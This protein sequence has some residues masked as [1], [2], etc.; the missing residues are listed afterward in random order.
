MT[1]TREHSLLAAILLL[2]LAARIVY[3]VVQERRLDRLV[4]SDQGTYH[5]LACNLLEKGY[6]GIEGLCSYRSV[7]PPLYPFFL[8]GVYSLSGVSWPAARV[9][10]AALATLA[11]LALFLLAREIAG[12]G[13]ALFASLLFSVDFYLIHLS[14]IFL[15]ENL[16]LP[17]S[18]LL[19]FFLI[20]SF[21]KARWR[22][23]AL[24]G[25][26]AG[27]SALCRP[28]VILFLMLLGVVPRALKA[29]RKGIAGWLL[30]LG[31]T[32]LVISPWTFRNYRVHQRFVPISTN[33]GI[34]L[35]VG[36]HPGAT[37]GYD[38]PEENNP[39]YRIENEV[40]R[41][42][43]MGR[44]AMG[45]IIRYPGEFLKLAGKKFLLFWEFYPFAWSGRQGIIYL[46]F[47]IGGFVLSLRDWRRWLI[48]YL[49]VFSIMATHLLFESGSRY[50]LPLNPIIEIWAALAVVALAQRRRR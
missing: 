44:E 38:F 43:V 9:A 18:L 25:F 5:R 10:Q 11:C 35:W 2:C 16:Y 41:N 20:I 32:G 47:G 17:L 26:L 3:A 49:Y 24:G 28:T 40:E 34:V 48:V 46:A 22:L 31:V 13:V 1:R 42:N 39:F 33:G 29:G 50:R 15:S 7:R 45:F 12:A 27:L 4:I 23:F 30:M 14:G 37:G 21:Q 19:L 36:L 6:Y 8:A